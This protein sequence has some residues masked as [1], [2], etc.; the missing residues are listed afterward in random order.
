MQNRDDIYQQL[1][2]C[3]LENSFRYFN[4]NQLFS[5][6]NFFI[7]LNA[8]PKDDILEIFSDRFKIENLSKEFANK[9]FEQILNTNHVYMEIINNTNIPTNNFANTFKVW[10]DE[11]KIDMQIVHLSRKLTSYIFKSKT[12]IYKEL[13]TMFGPIEKD[14][15]RWID[16]MPYIEV[17]Y[18]NKINTRYSYEKITQSDSF[19]APKTKTHYNV[20]LTT[21]NLLSAECSQFD[22]LEN[23]LDTCASILESKEFYSYFQ[24]TPAFQKAVWKNKKKL[25]DTLRELDHRKYFFDADIYCV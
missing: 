20:Y 2:V 11:N 9:I 5:L 17:E 3:F 19:I 7:S 18:Y 14:T 13:L 21:N 25:T 8:L 23:A 22:T 4:I 1:E 15:D 10:A 12:P 6:K 16:V 24:K